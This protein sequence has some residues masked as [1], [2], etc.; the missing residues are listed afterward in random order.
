MSNLFPGDQI[1]L[2]RCLCAAEFFLGVLIS[3]VGGGFKYFYFCP[4]LARW[5]ILTVR[6][7]FSKG[8]G[9]KPPPRKGFSLISQMRRMCGLYTYNLQ[10]ELN[11]LIVRWNH[12]PDN[13]IL[14]FRSVGWRYFHLPSPQ[15]SPFQSLEKHPPGSSKVVCRG[16]EHPRCVRSTRGVC[17]KLMVK[18]SW[19]FFSICAESSTLQWSLYTNHKDSCTCY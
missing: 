14:L 19:D 2:P 8:V 13:W 5:S 1:D 18:K 17:V 10:N 6:I 4:Y 11:P 16:E 7:F 12:Q 3:I 9:E 15:E